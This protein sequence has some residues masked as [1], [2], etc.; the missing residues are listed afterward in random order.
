MIEIKRADPADENK[1]GYKILTKNDK[2]ISKKD[3]LQN[4]FAKNLS[5]L[6]SYF[7]I[8]L[9]ITISALTFILIE[10]GILMQAAAHQ[11]ERKN[12]VTFKGNPLTLLGN[13]LKTGMKAPDFEVLANDLSPVKLAD[14]QNKIKVIS[15]V[16]SIDTPVC[17]AQTRK[18][19]EAA[20][21]FSTDTVVLTISMDLPF[22]QARWCGAAGIDKVIT[23]S[24]HKNAAFG[25]N[26]GTLISELRLL[27]RA[28][29]IVDKENIIR[30]IE[31]V[32]EVTSHPDYDKAIQNLKLIK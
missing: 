21:S 6:H 12:A 13:E 8:S 3:F 31:Y 30:Y 22:A 5:C 18:F 24:D 32:P 27:S 14:Y 23:L 2:G 29:F 20:A 28:V 11:S 1:N 25:L 26:Y 7:M 9:L 15:V 17:D 4:L 19:N 16:P 10:G